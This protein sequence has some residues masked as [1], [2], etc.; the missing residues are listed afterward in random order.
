MMQI[1]CS[2]MIYKK[3]KKKMLFKAILGDPPTIG[4]NS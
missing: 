2:L 4:G 3:V 1:L